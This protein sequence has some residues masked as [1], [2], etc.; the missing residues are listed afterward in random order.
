MF[1]RGWY[2]NR[3]CKFWGE[4]NEKLIYIYI[5]IS[6]ITFLVVSSYY[7]MWFYYLKWSNRSQ[8]PFMQAQKQREFWNHWNIPNNLLVADF[9]ISIPCFCYYVWYM[10]NFLFLGVLRYWQ[11][12]ACHKR[13]EPKFKLRLS[14]S[15]YELING[16]KTFFVF[17]LAWTFGD[18]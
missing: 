18:F 8:Q 4:F 17:V 13:T 11:K 1:S 3:D 9:Y 6:G 5:F 12:Q 16:S 10:K 14:S 7:K 2:S 15:C